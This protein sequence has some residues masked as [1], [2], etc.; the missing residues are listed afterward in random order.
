MVIAQ[1]SSSAENKSAEISHGPQ[2]KGKART[3]SG[4]VAI[5]RLLLI[6][7]VGLTSSISEEE[8]GK[9]LAFRY[10][11]KLWRVSDIAHIGSVVH[12][13][14]PI[15]AYNDAVKQLVEAEAIIERQINEVAGTHP[16]EMKG[17]TMSNNMSKFFSQGFGQVRAMLA[18]VEQRLR[19]ICSITVCKQTITKVL[20]DDE[21]PHQPP[22]VLDEQVVEALRNKYDGLSNRTIDWSSRRRN[23]QQEFVESPVEREYSYERRH[24]RY[25]DKRQALIGLASLLSVG[26]SLYTTVELAAL[27]DQVFTVGHNQQIIKAVIERHRQSININNKA[28]RKVLD[29]LQKDEFTQILEMKS[30]KMEN[31]L[32]LMRMSTENINSYIEDLLDVLINQKLSPRFFDTA[33]IQDAVDQLTEQG[34]AVDLEPAYKTLTALLNSDLSFQI[35]DGVL[36]LFLHVPMVTRTNYNLYEYHATPLRLATGHTLRI[37]TSSRFLAVD[38]QM[39]SFAEF[40]DS[41]IA[42]CRWMNGGHLCEG[43]V[44]AKSGDLSCLASLFTSSKAVTSVCLFQQ[45]NEKKESV[46][47]MGSN[48]V[49][50]VAPTHSTTMAFVNCRETSSS[51][52]REIETAASIEV[53]PGCSLSTPN[54]IFQSMFRFEFRVL[55]VARKLKGL[56]AINVTDYVQSTDGVFGPNINVTR[57]DLKE[58]DERIDTAPFHSVGMLVLMAVGV[59]LGV[60][61]IFAVGYLVWRQNR[62]DRERRRRRAAR[63]K[64]RDGSQE[65]MLDLSPDPPS[66]PP[67][68]RETPPRPR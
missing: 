68:S 23:P 3:E 35:Q 63:F 65:E 18:E 56:E 17:R 32:F 15:N 36:T 25:R 55:Y 33:V 57:V 61:C 50:V 48:Q 53:P 1:E 46:I 54:F 14:D 51:F 21:M 4:R 49:V 22:T 43:G 2:R 64:N 31:Y 26:L 29:R 16:S 42:K 28:I 8:A 13:D 67:K 40:E 39:T 44:V 7:L 30:H 45:T 27:K 11:G 59:I 24:Q 19:Y 38:D 62:E 6:S 10:H 52:E 41:D 37:I 20:P 58:E 5:L 12:L 9:S 47:Q 60:M 66:R 34:N